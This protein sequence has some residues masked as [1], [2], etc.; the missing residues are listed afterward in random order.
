MGISR[1]SNLLRKIT[2]LF[3]ICCCSL[4][5]QA[6]YSGGTGEPNNPY[7]ISD[8]NDLYTLA[9]DTNDYD[10]CF[11]MTNDIDLDP[12]LPGRRT[13]T[14]ALIA[15][16]ILSGYP[17]SGTPFTGHFDGNDFRILNLTIETD[18]P[19]DDYI[20]MFGHIREN[21]NITN[22]GLQGAS[23]NSTGHYLG[24]LC[25]YNYYGSISNCYATVSLK[26]A[27]YSRYLGGLIGYSYDGTITNCNVDGSVNSGRDS[28]E[29]GGLV[30]YS[31]SGNIINCYSTASVTAHDGSAALGGLVGGGYNC[32]VTN[33]YATGSVSSGSVATCLG[34]L[35]GF[36]E[37]FLYTCIIFN[38]YA[39]GYIK[40]GPGST[41]LTLGGLSGSYSLVINSYFL[42]PNDGGGRDNGIGEPLRDWQMKMETSFFTWE[43]GNT[44]KI[45]EGESYPQLVWQKYSG[46]QGT[47]QNPYQIQTYCDL[48]AL[49]EDINDYNKCFIMTADI[50]LDPAL[51]GRKVLTNALIAPDFLHTFSGTFDGNNFCI[52]NL[53][54]DTEGIGRNDLALFGNIESAVIS[55][56]GMENVSV[57]GGYKSWYLGA[58]GA[59]NDHGIISNCHATGNITAGWEALFFGGLVGCNYY[60]TVS[61]CYSAANVT[62]E[63]QS[64]NIGGLCG[65]NSYGTISNCYAIGNVTV[66]SNSKYIGGLCGYNSLGSIRNCYAAGNVDG[67]AYIGGLCG[68][69]YL[70]SIINCYSKATVSGDWRVGG[71]C[72]ENIGYITSCCATGIVT[73]SVKLGGLCGYNSYGNIIN[74]YATATVMGGSNSEHIGGLCG[75]NSGS[76]SNCYSTGTVSGYVDLGGLC[77]YSDQR[78][79][80]NCYFL[81]TSGPDNGYGTPLTDAQMKQQNSFSGWDFNNETANGTSQIWMM[82]PGEYPDIYYFDESF[83]QY[84]FIGQGTEL[85][86][87]LIYDTCDLGAIWQKPDSHY[88][89]ENDIDLSDMTF[90]TAIVVSFG[91]TFDGSGYVI[92]NLNINGGSYLGAF[93]RMVGQVINLGIQDSSITGGDYSRCLGGLCAENYKGSIN[94]CYVIGNMAGGRYS[95]NLGG[96]CGTNAEGNISYC[97]TKGNLTHQGHTSFAN[98]GGLCGNNS[99]GTITNSYSTANV[100]GE[101]I[102]SNLGG[103]CGSNTRDGII[104]ECYST[105]SVN[106][107]RYLGGLCGD[108][109]LGGDISNCYAR[110]IVN[111]DDY[112]G[113]LC[114]R[115]YESSITNCYSTGSVN[116]DSY[117]GGFCGYS[118]NGI[119]SSCY[120]LYTSGPSNGNGKPRT[121]SE[122]KQQDNFINWDFNDIWDICEN[123]NYPRLQWLIPIADLIC[124][125]GVNFIDYAFFT[126]RWMDQNC[127]LL[128]DYCQGTDLDQLGTVDIVDFRIFADNWLRSF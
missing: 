79:I 50:D 40:A 86:P 4:S 60:G 88:R 122:L 89:M 93:G 25:G 100:S 10:K 1:S 80:S 16:D 97:Y 32:I 83:T 12:N 33:C 42:D 67:Y 121:D 28:T 69:N 58:L 77:G 38:C 59:Y 2:I 65:D 57:T 70:G 124:P 118:V 106:G 66:G 95:R 8:Y 49:A 41:L 43:F 111:G 90:S 115:N 56:I 7:R 104:T 103:L 96:L 24:A 62:G 15:P 128:N 19:T 127:D 94:N 36:N 123:Q 11:V 53:T 17:F 98:L 31:S 21:G 76:F 87:Y 63:D 45:C 102:S 61:N 51:T 20:G 27:L 18:G 30:G 108:N 52:L 99:G 64:R 119:F 29:L 35:L 6:K 14:T 22:L 112:I 71:L 3:V 37:N 74:C 47:A 109:W 85:N 68:Y 13:L 105:G 92:R 101:Y 82:P 73:G 55:N 107:Y 72:G 125:D 54:I 116:G 114:G 44:W 48:Y 34:G 113:G 26:G 46:G 39:T 23:I 84:E 126:D 110:G 120:F 81:D 78:C 75:Y 91:G 9:D 117:L 5:A